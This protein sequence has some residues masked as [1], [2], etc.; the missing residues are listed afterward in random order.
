LANWDGFSRTNYFR[1]KDVAAF[2]KTMEQY[3]VQVWTKDDTDTCDW[4]GLGANDGDWPS[5][6]PETDED[7]WFP[8]ILAKHLVDGEVAI[9]QTVGAERLRYLT[10]YAI[11]INGR[12]EHVEVSINQIYDLAKAKFGVEPTEAC[13]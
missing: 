7:I 3:E 12:G 1:V 10:G 2:R 4:F 13:Y 11:A 9:L 8:E 6:N 5:Y